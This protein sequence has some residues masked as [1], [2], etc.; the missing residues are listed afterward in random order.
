VFYVCFTE[1]EIKDE[2][3]EWSEDPHDLTSALPEDLEHVPFKFTRL[4]E[5]EMLKRSQDFFQQLNARRT[6]RY[7]SKDH[8]PLEVIKNIIRT[9][10]NIN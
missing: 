6:L 7:F 3:E 10:G 4:S 1:A 2:D 5:G 9:A 8:V